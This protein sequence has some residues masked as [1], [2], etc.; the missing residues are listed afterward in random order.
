[1]HPSTLFIVPYRDRAAHRRVLMRVLETNLVD[2]APGSYK[3]VFIHQ[4]DARPFNRGAMK[5]IGAIWAR[6]EYRDAY[7]D[8]TLVFHD[9]DTWPLPG[10]R[11]T[12]IASPGTVS[13]FYGFDF[14]LGGI[15]GI[16]GADFD[17]TGGFPNL[18]GWGLED[19]SFLDRC[20]KAGLGIDRSSFHGPGDPLVERGAESPVRTIAVGEAERYCHGELDGVA[21]ITDLYWERVGDMVNVRAFSAGTSHRDYAYQGHDV[22]SGPRIPV[23]RSAARRMWGMG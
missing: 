18:W 1:M 7:D 12:Y 5:N 10:S 6:S 23:Y 11:V 4:D 15:V 16:K 17:R 13:H 22:R 9:V 3:V 19:N 21:D 8:M 20:I 14:S 2:W